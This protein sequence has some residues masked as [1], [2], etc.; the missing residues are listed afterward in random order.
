VRRQH[1]QG[2][3]DAQLGMA[4]ASLGRVQ[5]HDFL[6]I[7]RPLEEIDHLGCAGDNQV[8]RDGA[9]AIRLRFDCHSCTPFTTEPVTLLSA[10]RLMQKT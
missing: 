1:H 6:R 4:D 3:V 2:V 10:G 9:M 7:E 8:R 5:P